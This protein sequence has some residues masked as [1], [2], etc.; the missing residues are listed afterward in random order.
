[1][2]EVYAVL[3]YANLFALVPARCLSFA[4]GAAL[5]LAFGVVAGDV[6]E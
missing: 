2:T 5:V 4:C 6:L 3:F 1:M